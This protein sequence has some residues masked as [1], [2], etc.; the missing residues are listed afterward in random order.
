MP[1][2]RQRGSMVPRHPRSRQFHA[3][4]AKITHGIGNWLHEKA[5][6]CNGMVYA[7]LKQP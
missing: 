6:F 5:D 7:P 3:V 2:A 1:F 4:C